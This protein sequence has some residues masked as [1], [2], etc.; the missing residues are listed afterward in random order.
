MALVFDAATHAYTLNGVNIPSVTRT[1]DHAGLVSYEM[2]RQDILEKKSWLGIKVHEACHYY[3]QN[4]LNWASLDE[5]VKPRLDA[6][7][8]FR[9]DTGFVP[10]RIEARFVATVNGMTYGLTVDREG[11]FKKQ[12]AIIDLK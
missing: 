2:V 8:S 9:A 6:W 11:V 5:D 1:L 7:A 3:D 12:E 4:D 10:Q